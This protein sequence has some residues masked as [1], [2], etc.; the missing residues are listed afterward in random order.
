M[1]FWLGEGDLT[2]FPLVKDGH[3]SCE[4]YLLTP[5]AIGQGPAVAESA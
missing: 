1:S 2:A 4:N 3:C 5:G